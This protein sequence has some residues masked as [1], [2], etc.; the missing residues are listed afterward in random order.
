MINARIAAGDFVLPIYLFVCIVLGG[1]SQSIWGKSILQFLAVLIVA[2]AIASPR[3]RLRLS[4]TPMILGAAVLA[5]FV[6][7]LI[8]LPPSIWSHLPGREMVVEGY[9]SFNMDLPWL[10]LSLSPYDSFEALLFFLPPTAVILLA[11]GRESPRA[12]WAAWTMVGATLLSVLLGYL[13]ISSGRFEQS[14]WYLYDN[15]N[16]GAAVGFFAN[17][18]HMGTLLLVA[19]PFTIAIASI[20]SAR[21][22]GSS[23][24]IWVGAGAALLILSLGIAMNGS[25]AA[26]LLAGPAILLSALLLPGARRVRGLVLAV[27]VLGFGAATLVLTNSPVQ[28]ELTGKDTSSFDGRSEIWSTTL[29]AAKQ[30][31]PVGTGLGTFQIAYAT[32]EDADVVT[33]T[34]VNHA[35]NDYLEIA[36]EGGAIGALVLAAFLLWWAKIATGAWQAG[37]EKALSRAAVAASGVILASSFV[38]YPLRTTSIATIFAFLVAVAA[39]PKIESSSPNTTEGLRHLRYH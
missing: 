7:H 38:D 29:A 37:N 26:V 13:Q 31:F 19:I 30:T 16:V 11:V 34:Y 3:V 4:R 17:R 1:S 9:R 21:A 18:N 12:E 6:L 36:L 2:W 23:V 33:Q 28:A 24:P 8:P 25:L 39:R 35:H 14:G 10:P 5:L 22:R 15:T 20:A 32:Y 27:A